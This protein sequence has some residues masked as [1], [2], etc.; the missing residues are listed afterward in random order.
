MCI[1]ECLYMFTVFQ[2][3]VLTWTNT[4]F[5]KQSAY[6]SHIGK[7]VDRTNAGEHLRTRSSAIWRKWMTF[8]S[9]CCLLGYSSVNLVN[10][11]SLAVTAIFSSS[12]ALIISTQ[13]RLTAT[14]SL[15]SSSWFT[16]WLITTKWEVISNTFLGRYGSLFLNPYDV[17]AWV[18]IVWRT[19]NEV[20]RSVIKCEWISL[21]WGMVN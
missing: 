20:N 11:S 3:S 17:T 12:I 8:T 10:I 15:K 19:I 7:M 1:L 6:L 18:R 4:S 2:V 16:R 9:F 21:S 14:H 13:R 5:V